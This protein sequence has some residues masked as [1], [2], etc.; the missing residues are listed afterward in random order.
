MSQS[1]LQR[2]CLVVIALVTPLLAVVWLAPQPRA[3]AQQRPPFPPRPPRPPIF[4]PPT[5][6]RPPVPT[7]NIPAPPGVP[8]FENVWSCSGCKTE[9]GRG[10]VRPNLEACPKCKTRFGNT[11]AGMMANMRDRMNPGGANP[12][13]P[14]Q[15][16]GIPGQP[17]LPGQPVGMPAQPQLPAPGMRNVRVSAPAT[18]RRTLVD[19]TGPRESG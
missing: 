14:G 1:S 18:T 6:P 15:P 2:R 8:R 5:M 19:V 7:P 12:G 11:A 10:P 4:Q 9:L 13:V 17:V 16:A 3:N